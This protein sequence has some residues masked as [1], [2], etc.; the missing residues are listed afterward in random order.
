[1]KRG[2]PEFAALS[3]L[4]QVNCYIWTTTISYMIKHS[5]ISENIGKPFLWMTSY[6]QSL[7]NFSIKYTWGKYLPTFFFSVKMYILHVS[8]N[9][10][11][12]FK[13]RVRSW[14]MWKTEITVSLRFSVT[15]FYSAVHTYICTLFIQSKNLVFYV[16]F[17]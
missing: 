9:Q 17:L 14:F 3:D 5:R 16:Y 13:I 7:T 10:G 6:V 1:M 4:E 11:F 15:Q 2:E 12:V 8:W